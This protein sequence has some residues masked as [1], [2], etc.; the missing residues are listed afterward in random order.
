VVFDLTVAVQLGIVAACVT[1]IVRIARL[2]RADALAPPELKAAG[3][4]VQVKRL[5][6]RCSSARPRWSRLCR[7]S[8]PRGR[9]CSTSST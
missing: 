7:T 5:S 3:T 2:S 9:W 8:C 6:A 1:F 4:Q